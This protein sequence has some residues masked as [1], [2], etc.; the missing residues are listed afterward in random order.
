[1]RPGPR[2]TAFIV[3]V[4]V[5]IIITAFISFVD[6]A[7]GNIIAACFIIS[8]L[9][10]LISSLIYTELFYAREMTFMDILLR[11]IEN[12]DLEGAKKVRTLTPMKD[13]HRR[14]FNYAVSRNNEV[15][16]LTQ[17]ANFRK[18][19]IAD[20]SHELK[21][22]IF[23][24]QGFVHTLIDGA[25]K[26]KR[27]R[28]KFLKKAA[29]SLDRLD[30]LVQDLVTLSQIEIGEVKMFFEYFDTKK[31]AG[32]VIEEF[33][34]RANKKEINLKIEIEEG[35]EYIVYAD[36]HR[37]YQVLINLVGNAMEYTDKG[38]D[39]TIQLQDSRDHIRVSVK[40]TG[41]GI[42]KDHLPRIFERFYRVDKSR[43]R[44]GGGT[45]L[46]LT[47]SQNLAQ[48][49]GGHIL[50]ESKLNEGSTFTVTIPAAK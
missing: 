18:D 28:E 5:A 3:S 24:A 35:K 10:I 29:K 7:T 45:G 23:A 15:R 6:G 34:Q 43:S 14:I 17:M 38:G 42:P 31:L 27:V 22:P 13:V 12:N 25:V 30:I 26:D 19:F 48:L 16:R 20:I 21:T 44:S 50:V 1:M 41:V 39:V 49:M 33:E 32:E 8:F 11:R 47:I 37:I 36:W 9:I 2:L 4:L 46:G 40:D